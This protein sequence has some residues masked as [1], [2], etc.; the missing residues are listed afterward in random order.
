MLV[1]NITYV[2]ISRFPASDLRFL[3]RELFTLPTLVG[4][5]AVCPSQLVAACFPMITAPTS[6]LL[7]TPS[8]KFPCQDLTSKLL[9]PVPILLPGQL[10]TLGVLELL[11]LFSIARIRPFSIVRSCRSLAYL[12][13]WHSRLTFRKE[14]RLPPSC[15]FK[16]LLISAGLL[17]FLCLQT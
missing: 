1:I 14:R 4:S 13:L 9:Q 3:T 11:T 6:L 10:V 2:L 5:L 7:R 8:P 16:R 15:Q 12:L 17:A